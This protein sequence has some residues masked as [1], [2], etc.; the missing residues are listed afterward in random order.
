VCLCVF[1]VKCEVLN[2]SHETFYNEMKRLQCY[3]DDYDR[4]DDRDE[5]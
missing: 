5:E 2:S 4:K 3:N 1:S